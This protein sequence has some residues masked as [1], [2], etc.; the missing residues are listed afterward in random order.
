MEIWMANF[1]H[2][3]KSVINGKHPCVILSTWKTCIRKGGNIQVVPLTSN[4]VKYVDAHI[5]L[6][7]YNLKNESKAMCNEI[8]SIDKESLLFKIGKITDAKTQIEIETAVENQLDLSSNN[9]N[10]LDLENLFVDNNSTVNNDKVKLENLKSRVYAC[11][12]S[13]EYEEAIILALELEEL[14]TKCKIAEKSEFIWYSLYIQATA[15]LGLGN[16]EL[17]LDKIQQALRYISDPKKFSHSYSI[18]VWAL[19]NCYEDMGDIVK[20]CQIYKSLSHHYKNEGETILRLQCVFSTASLKLNQKAM[21]NIY[22][23]LKTVVVTNRT[24]QNCESYK[25]EILEAM[26]SELDVLNV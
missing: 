9:Y 19:S 21:K 1:D 25:K 13:R 2:N 17:A 3:F 7:G 22:N 15:N 12:H 23:I 6:K 20:A 16:K 10:A 18:S 26:K 14:S 11:D 4:L 8:M 5:D 24:I